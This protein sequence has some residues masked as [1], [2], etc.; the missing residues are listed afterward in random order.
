[1]E[2]LHPAADIGMASRQSV[3]FPIVNHQFSFIQEHS[4]HV[5]RL[6]GALLDRSINMID[7]VSD[8]SEAIAIIS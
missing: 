6:N 5:P 7:C 4:E 1:M 3:S 2:A 8:I